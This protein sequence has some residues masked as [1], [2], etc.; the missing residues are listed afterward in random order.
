MKTKI[1]QRWVFSFTAVFGLVG[2]VLGQL[3][4]G[5]FNFS[6]ALGAVT[7]ALFIF[8]LELI[9]NRIKRDKTP[10]FDERTKHNML[11]YYTIIAHVFIGIALL[12]L[13]IVTSSGTEQISINYLWIFIT[14]YLLISGIGALFVSR[15]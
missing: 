14:A 10:D 2:M 13:A 4:Q 5:E 6:V 11:K 1:Y 9:K 12:L 7:G 15:K 8:I 3:I